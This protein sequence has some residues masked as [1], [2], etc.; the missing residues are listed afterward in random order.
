[1][2]ESQTASTSGLLTAGSTFLRGFF[3]LFSL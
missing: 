1:M 3:L 2:P